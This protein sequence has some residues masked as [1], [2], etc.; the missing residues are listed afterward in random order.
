MAL[1]SVPRLDLRRRVVTAV[2]MGGLIQ[3]IMEKV[4]PASIA[5]ILIDFALVLVECSFLASTLPDGRL[6]P[7]TS[8]EEELR[9]ERVLEHDIEDL[10]DKMITASL[11]VRWVCNG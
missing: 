9:G 7:R 4:L 6:L 1:F 5:G 3:N 8:E 11:R 2:F 10:A